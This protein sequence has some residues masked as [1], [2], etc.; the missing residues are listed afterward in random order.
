MLELKDG[1]GNTLLWAIRTFHFPDQ[2]LRFLLMDVFGMVAR[3][4]T[5]NLNHLNPIGSQK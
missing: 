3:N 2:K 4:A 1:D 5:G